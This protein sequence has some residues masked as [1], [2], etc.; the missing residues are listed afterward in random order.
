[1]IEKYCA[2]KLI[3][4]GLET[5]I[6]SPARYDD[7]LKDTELSRQLEINGEFL[8][9]LINNAAKIDE[10]KIHLAFVC[11]KAWENHIWQP[12]NVCEYEDRYYHVSIR[13]TWLCRECGHV[14]RGSIIMPMAEADAVFLDKPHFRDFEIPA[15]SKKLPCE[16]CGRPLQNHLII[17]K[18]D[19]P[20]RSSL[21]M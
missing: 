21:R 13:D 9:V 20:P 19:N 11:H 12:I 5:Y 18:Q 8:K 2:K 10:M 4:D 16:I 14:H 1:M 15:I 3:V 7:I 6:I 17:I